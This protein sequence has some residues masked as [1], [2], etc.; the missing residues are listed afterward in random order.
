MTISI[1]KSHRINFHTPPLPIP[2]SCPNPIQRRTELS[3]RWS[4]FKAAFISPI[5]S[6]SPIST[7][8]LC[9]GPCEREILRREILS[10]SWDPSWIV[11]RNQEFVVPVWPLPG[12]A[13][14]PTRDRKSGTETIGKGG[15]VRY[16]I[17][18]PNLFFASTILQ[19]AMR[20]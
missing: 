20:K 3:K 11:R 15:S 2:L 17:R 18:S 9:R 4:Y 12:Q 19:Q 13:F 7:L 5:Q 6:L 8:S 10:G 14:V 16:S 1:G